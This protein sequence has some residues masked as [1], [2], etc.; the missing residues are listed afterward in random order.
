MS[1]KTNTP[2]KPKTV[3]DVVVKQETK[4]AKSKVTIKD[5]QAEIEHLSGLLM[6]RDATIATLTEEIKSLSINV[7]NC[8]IFKQQASYYKNQLEEELGK[9]FW[10]RL[11]GG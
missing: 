7:E 5:L 3:K 9:S 4:P 2:K 1:N 8:E 6:V 11:I 10:Q